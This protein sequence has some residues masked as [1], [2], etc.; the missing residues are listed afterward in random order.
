MMIAAIT[1]N[2]GIC[3]DKMHFLNMF[4]KDGYAISQSDFNQGVR[5][6]DGLKSYASEAIGNWGFQ[7][8]STAKDGE[9]KMINGLLRHCGTLHS[10]S[11]LYRVLAA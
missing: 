11:K 8:S 9:G 3:G 4:Q 7:V 1:L 6:I 5:Y 10:S 2:S